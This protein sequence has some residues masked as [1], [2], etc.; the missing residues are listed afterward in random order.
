[1]AKGE[2]MTSVNRKR[3]RTHQESC[4]IH[5]SWCDSELCKRLLQALKI[6]ATPS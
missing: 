5:S 4:I 1:M 6:K 3:I 2:K